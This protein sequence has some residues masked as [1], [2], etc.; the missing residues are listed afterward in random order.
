MIDFV[1]IAIMSALQQR[2]H[3]FVEKPKLKTKK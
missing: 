1:G 2:G 3:K